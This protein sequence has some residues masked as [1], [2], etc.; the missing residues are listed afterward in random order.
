MPAADPAHTPP[1]IRNTNGDAA[2]ID[3]TR[4]GRRHTSQGRWMD[5]GDPAGSEPDAPDPGS[6][7]PQETLA[8]LAERFEETLNEYRLSLTDDKVSTTFL[9][10]LQIVSGML[11]GA[12]AQG[13][14]DEAQYTKLNAMVKGMISAARLV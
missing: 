5:M 1:E 4:A 6:A 13:V 10:T 12:R 11:D 3:I 2:V 14:V 7:D 9:V 8:A